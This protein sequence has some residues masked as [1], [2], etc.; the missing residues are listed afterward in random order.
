VKLV[1]VI[2]S[3]ARGG[4]ERVTVNLANHLAEEGWQISIVTMAD[5]ARDCYELHPDIHR[6]ALALDSESTNP[7]AAVAS[8]LRRI[9]AL[10]G[11]LRSERP[12][13][14]LGMMNTASVLLEFAA[15]GLGIVTIG[16][17]RANPSTAH[18]GRAWAWLRS[19]AYRR[20]HAVVAL[21]PEA[22]RW[23]ELHA[24][25]RNIAVIPNAV[26][27][28]LPDQAPRVDPQAVGTAGRKR[29]M[30]VGRLAPVKGTDNLVRA[31]ARIAA[32][33]ADWELVVVGEGPQRAALQA[34]I[35]SSGL[36]GQVILAGEVGN[37]A[38]WYRRAE[39]FV[40]SSRHEGFPN[41]LLEA[42]AHGVASV[43]FDCEAGPRNIIRH[44]VDG[45]LVPDQDVDALAA[46][47]ELM[48]DDR[49]LRARCAERAMEVRERFAVARILGMWRDLI[50]KRLGL[51][52][53][54]DIGQGVSRPV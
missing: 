8:N 44:G 35:D 24:G 41:V 2:H 32:R 52:G 43:S 21:T 37:L 39:L 19:V 17:E 27:W 54:I 15:R 33:H 36:A 34:Q 29:L 20:L 45:L 40:L 22:A 38:E 50:T 47:L 23:L 42:M 25:A 9:F 10:R 1:V 49:E 46:A 7:L 12:D 18:P 13:V 4:A 30:T 5:A 53:R 48:M 31:F 3:L 16:A 51:D 14:A 6:V 26:V 11:I 28:P